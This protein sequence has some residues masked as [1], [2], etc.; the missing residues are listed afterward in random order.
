MLLFFNQ[1]C[2]FLKIPVFA[3]DPSAVNPNSIKK[4]LANNMITSFIN[5]KPIFINGPRRLPRNPPD[6]IVRYLCFQ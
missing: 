2:F 3:T 1:V 4:L 5:A 6:F